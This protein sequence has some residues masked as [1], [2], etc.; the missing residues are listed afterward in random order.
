M[1]IFK[2]IF[3]LL[4]G[5]L[6]LLPAVISFS[7]IFSGHGHELCVNYSDKHF[8]STSLDCELHSYQQGPALAKDFINFEPLVEKQVKK[9][10]FDFYQFLNDYHKLPFELRG[11]PIAA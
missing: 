11:P 7:H 5:V 9:Q 10:F 4:L 2:H 6:L 8:H 3:T 1:K